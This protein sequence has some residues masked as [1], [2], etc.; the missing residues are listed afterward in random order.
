MYILPNCY[1]RRGEDFFMGLDIESFCSFICCDNTDFCRRSF[2][3][4]I[5]I[6]S[7]PR[8]QVALILLTFEIASSKHFCSRFLASC[9]AVGGFIGVTR[10]EALDH[11]DEDQQV[12]ATT[13]HTYVQPCVRSYCE[14]RYSCSHIVFIV[15]NRSLNDKEDLQS[16]PETSCAIC[17][18]VVAWMY[19]SE[20]YVSVACK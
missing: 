1:Y 12:W 15:A 9:L 16:I 17:V 19:S 2:V 8:D 14:G 3:V 7:G 10:Q 18:S 11:N 6:M 20:R 13:T 4:I 5:L